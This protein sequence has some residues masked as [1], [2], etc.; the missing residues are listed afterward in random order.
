ML[1]RSTHWLM[2]TAALILLLALGT[3]GIAYGYW[4]DQLQVSGAVQ[5]GRLDAKWTGYS[6]F[7]FN[8]WPALPSDPGGY[9]EPGGEDIGS[10]VV[11]IDS[12][13]PTLLH[14]RIEDGYP[15]YSVVCMFDFEN[16]GSIPW[17]VNGNSIFAGNN[18]SGCSL[19]GGPTSGT[20]TLTCNELT[21]KFKDNVN[22]IFEPQDGSSSQMI[23]HIN[24]DAE[25]TTDYQFSIRSCLSQWNHPMDY[26]SC[27]AT[28]P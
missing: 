6:C 11:S 5:T 7:E 17:I 25:E 10:T 27:L 8:T 4:T 21:I 23:V 12:S 13:D 14:F 19:S 3:M 18:L 9:T 26:S 28:L 20:K 1:N 2:G 16:S 15:G 24:D 22:G